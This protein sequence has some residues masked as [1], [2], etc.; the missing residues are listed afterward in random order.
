MRRWTFATRTE[1]QHCR[2][3][4]EFH[5]PPGDA[6][7]AL[8]WGSGRIDDAVGSFAA[9]ARRWAWPPEV[10]KTN[11]FLGE[12]YRRIVKRAGTTNCHALKLGDGLRLTSPQR[13][14]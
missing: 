5:I 8:K 6:S 3:V 4:G 12:R 2:C 13:S 7:Q 14:G 9:R 10:A 11:T 1:A